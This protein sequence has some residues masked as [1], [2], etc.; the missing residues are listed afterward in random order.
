MTIS[1]FLALTLKL[2]SAAFDFGRV[3]VSVLLAGG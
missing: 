1:H 2:F 3:L